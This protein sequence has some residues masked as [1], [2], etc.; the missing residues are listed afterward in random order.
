MGGVLNSVYLARPM[1]FQTLI[2]CDAECDIHSLFL[3]RPAAGIADL[4]AQSIKE[5]DWIYP[6]QRAAQVI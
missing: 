1:R 2:A 4:H 6:L 5:H 3:H